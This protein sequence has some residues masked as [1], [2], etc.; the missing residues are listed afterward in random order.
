MQIKKK[1]YLWRRYIDTDSKKVKE[2][3]WSNKYNLEFWK[4][5]PTVCLKLATTKN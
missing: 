5:F 3:N 1:Y 4:V 2:I